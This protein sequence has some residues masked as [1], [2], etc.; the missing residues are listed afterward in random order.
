[1]EDLKC[2]IYEPTGDTETERPLLLIF[3]TGNFATVP[4]RW[5]ARDQVR[6][7]GSRS[8]YTLRQ[9]GYVVASCDYRLGWNPLAA[10]QEERTLQLI[11]QHTAVFRQPNG[12]SFLPQPMRR[13]AIL[14]VLTQK[15][16]Y[17]RKRNRR[18]HHARLFNDF[19]YNDIILDDMG[20]PITKFWYDPGDGSYIPWLLKV[21]TVIP[22]RRPTHTLLRLWVDSSC[23]RRTTLAT[24]L[25][26]SR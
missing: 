19:G 4:E 11:K 7:L 1:M 13:T 21:F 9:D 20:A 15:D 26:N 23:V 14:T 2:D 17:D 12:G 3:H 6:Q 10:T 8:G 25:N 18:L 5:T 16:R 24:A 22:T